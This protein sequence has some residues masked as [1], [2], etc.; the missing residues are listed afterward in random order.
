[1]PLKV[2]HVDA[3]Q[4]IGC[5]E[6]VPD[7]PQTLIEQVFQHHHRL[8]DLPTRTTTSGVLAT[9]RSD[10]SSTTSIAADLVQ[11]RSDLAVEKQRL[12]QRIRQA[13]RVPISAN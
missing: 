11:L 12:D 13:R 8:Q 4:V 6:T 1:M 5:I 9:P 7:S 2:G 10:W 3:E